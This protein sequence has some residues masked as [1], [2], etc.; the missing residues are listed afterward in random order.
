MSHGKWF[1]TNFTRRRKISFDNSKQSEN[2]LDF[3]AMI[4]LD[5][6]RID[7][8]AVKALGADL[9]F[10]QE[11]HETILDYEIEKFNAS[12][13][14]CVWVRM[15]V[16]LGN[17][18]CPHCWM[19]YNN[20]AASDAQNV[21]GV[22]DSNYL[23]VWHHAEDPSGGAPQILDS[24]SN[25]EDLTSLGVM[26]SD[27]LV[28]A[29]ICDG[30][31][32]DGS[33]DALESTTFLDSS[34]LSAVTFEAIF[35]S[36][37]QEGVLLT[38]IEGFK[39]LNF[40][41]DDPGGADPGILRWQ[42]STTSGTNTLLRTTGQAFND[43]I[44]HYAVGTYN[45]IDDQMILYVD[46]KEITRVTRNAAF[47]TFGTSANFRIGKISPSNSTPLDGIIDEFRVSDIARSADHIAVNF[48]NLFDK[49]ATYGTEQALDKNLPTG[50]TGEIIQL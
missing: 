36:T 49:F 3:P 32:L 43:D 7:Y 20:L 48:L 1:D 17:R 6:T 5:S 28:T 23:S 16:I 14:T 26:T 25:N 39:A 44:F 45:K 18:N 30:L 37:D 46:G 4:R 12:G 47:P 42:V 10:V 29:K 33:G 21:T 2:L 22:W 13:D 11:G 8:S 50:F 41:L 27:D 34:A 35:K 38:K 15:P 24:T 31:D 40:Q 9:R 19:Y